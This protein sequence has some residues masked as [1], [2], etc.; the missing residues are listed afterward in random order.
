[1][2][3]QELHTKGREAGQSGNYAEA[4]AFFEQAHELDP[5]WPFPIYDLSYTYLLKQDY[6]K[7]IA[8]YKQCNQMAPEGYYTAKT[9]LWALEKEQNGIFP[10]G[11]YLSY[12][13]LEWKEESERMGILNVMLAQN[14]NFT[15][16]YKSLQSLYSDPKERIEL[17]DKG[18]A[19]ETDDETYGMLIINKALLL[20]F[21]EKMTEAKQMLS[22]LLASNR[23]TV[24]SRR[25]AESI[26]EQWG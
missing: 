12:V 23:F 3:A 26:I 1:M 25:I 5:L 17:I 9:A 4:I 18:L 8:Y 6:E 20:S 19:L 15:P 22:D 16:A 14:P 2:T 21:Y 7:A 11:L 24:M 10:K 13:Q